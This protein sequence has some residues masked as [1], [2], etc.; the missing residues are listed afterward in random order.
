MFN[1]PTLKTVATM[2]LC[3]AVTSCGGSKDDPEALN[4]LNQAEQSLSANAPEKAITIIDSLNK[5]YPKELNVRRKAMYLRTLADSA[6][7]V[8]EAAQTDSIIKADSVI[9]LQLKPQFTF[10]KTKDMVE[11]Y[12]VA[13][14][15]QGHPLYERTGLEPRI[16]EQ[17][18]IFVASCVFG[19]AIN[20]VRLEASA[21]ASSA[22]TKDVPYDDST[23]Y[24]YT[25]DRGACEM[26]TFHIDK[27]EDFCKFIA[28]N[29]SS[30]IRVSY[31]GKG[32]TSITLSPELAKTFAETY[33][34]AQAMQSGKSASA[35]QIYLAKKKELN[36]QQMAR[37]AAEIKE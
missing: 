5:V 22:S 6:L 20:H 10:I 36:R 19:K 9:Y 34:F 33:Q 31:I 14:S 3:A 8:K 25:T 29:A 26:V 11:G 12:Y 2:L 37:T 18:N 16:D 30:K 23:N 4:M 35:K 1:E 13:K 15:L 7:I 28:D 21:A 32:R 27:C 17:G 24:R